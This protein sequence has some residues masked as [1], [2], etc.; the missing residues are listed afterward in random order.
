MASSNVVAWRFKDRIVS[1]VCGELGLGLLRAGG[2]LGLRVGRG[3]AL[4]SCL[5]TI[6]GAKGSNPGFRN[7]RIVGNVCRG[8]PF[9]LVKDARQDHYRR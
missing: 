2:V 5:R 8:V 1:G 7:E 3:G 6:S 9:Q 4:R